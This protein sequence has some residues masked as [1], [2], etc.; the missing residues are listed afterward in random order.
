MSAASVAPPLGVAPMARRVLAHLRPHRARFSAGVGLT[1]QVV[2]YLK[3]VA[4]ATGKNLQLDFFSPGDA[5]CEYSAVTTSTA[6]TPAA[7]WAFMAGR[8]AQA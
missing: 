4:H 2:I 7:L 6:L 3:R 5:H 1:L 8:G